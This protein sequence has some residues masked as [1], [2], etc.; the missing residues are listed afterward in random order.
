MT[1]ATKRNRYTLVL[2]IVAL[3]S[4]VIG[5]FF[6][7]AYW[8][9]NEESGFKTIQK[10][11]RQFLPIFDSSET[12]A[13]NIALKQTVNELR[14]QRD[15]CSQ[16]LNSQT[17]HLHQIQCNVTDQVKQNSI[18]FGLGTTLLY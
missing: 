14:Q 6:S 17:E 12:E 4:F 18:L 7:A 11:F 1:T 16:L 3:C 5:A 10:T 2:L 9:M 8:N 15:E 13:E